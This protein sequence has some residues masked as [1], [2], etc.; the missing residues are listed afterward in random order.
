MESRRGEVP[1]ELRIYDLNE[2]ALIDDE[3]TNNSI[4]FMQRQVK[5]AKPIL[6]FLRTPD[7]YRPRQP[8]E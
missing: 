2:R 7:P 3:L 8:Q 4:D 1:K 5:A 6:L